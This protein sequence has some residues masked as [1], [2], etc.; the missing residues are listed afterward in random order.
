MYTICIINSYYYI[1]YAI[2]YAHN[3]YL[4]FLF[5]YDFFLNFIIN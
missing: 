4:I 1:I 3:E 5:I 2:S